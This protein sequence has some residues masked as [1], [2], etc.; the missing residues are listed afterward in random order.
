MFDTPKLRRG[1]VWEVFPMRAVKNHIPDKLSRKLPKKPAKKSEVASV[2]LEGLASR[3]RN[4][5][6]SV[7]DDTFAALPLKKHAKIE[8]LIDQTKHGD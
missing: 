8:Q 1:R 3:R 7:V 2:D 4:K 6:R 5:A